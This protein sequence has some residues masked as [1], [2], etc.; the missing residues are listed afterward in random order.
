[1][2]EVVSLLRTSQLSKFSSLRETTWVR[3]VRDTIPSPVIFGLKSLVLLSSALDRER[4]SLSQDW[5]SLPPSSAFDLYLKADN[6]HCY[7]NDHATI[8]RTS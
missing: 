7:F 2:V 4:I 3:W 1:M 5:L 6:V 8:F